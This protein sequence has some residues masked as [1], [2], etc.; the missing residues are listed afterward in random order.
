MTEPKFDFDSVKFS[1]GNGKLED[2][3]PKSKPSKAIPP[4]NRG[5]PTKASKQ[6]ELEDEISGLLML[7]AMPLKMRD[8]HD[9][10]TMESC[11]DLFIQVTNKG[12]ALTPE[13]QTFASAL[14]T[15]AVDNKYLS[16]FFD[17]GDGAGKWLMLALATQPLIVGIAS[18]HVGHRRVH[19]ASGTQ[20]MV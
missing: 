19:N 7:I 15:C 1:E 5:R 12:A 2:P 11:A 13:A 9:Y 3:T 4:S 18:A 8:I 17:L 6:K 10:E 14:A 20:E 16:K